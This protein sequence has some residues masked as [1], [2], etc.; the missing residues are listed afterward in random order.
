MSLN[1]LRVMVTRPKPQGILLCEQIRLLGG[2][3]VYFPTI[4]I[5]PHGNSNLLSNL[6]QFNFLIFISPE[7]VYQSAKL[8]SKLPENV[9]FAAIGARTAKALEEMG[10]PAP[11]FPQEDWNS[12][13]LLKLPEMQGVSGKKIAIIKGLG[14]RQWLEEELERRGAKVNLIIVYQRTLPQIEVKPYVDLFQRGFV[15][16]IICTSNE[17]L[18][19]LKI[20]LNDA[21]SDLQK[22]PLLVISERMALWAQELGF[23]QILLSKNASQN[24]ILEALVKGN[25]YDK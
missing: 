20:L 11:I 24:A 12:E 4:E 18:Q 16:V 5:V 25:T 21:W 7:A 14:G 3:P 10:L 15:D 22:T 8:I 1:N 23:K 19:N 6:D 13:G 17:G 9:K 2:Q